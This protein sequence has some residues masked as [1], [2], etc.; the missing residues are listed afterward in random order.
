MYDNNRTI[1]KIAV[2][3]RYLLHAYLVKK[4]LSTTDTNPCDCLLS[5]LEILVKKSDYDA[6]LLR[7]K[8]M[9]EAAYAKL[10]AS[11]STICKAG[12]KE[13][14]VHNFPAVAKSLGTSIHLPFSVF[15]AMQDDAGMPEPCVDVR[16][17]FSTSRSEEVTAVGTSV[18][19]MEDAIYAEG[20]GASY[21]IA[22]HIFETDCKKGLQGRGTAWLASICQ[23]ISIPVYA[24]GGIT[25]DNEDSV[26]ASGAA[27]YC[28]MSRILDYAEES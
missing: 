18:H 12:G 14:I 5:L 4:R 10:A 2:T 8:D 26:L 15:S 13:L 27:G 9:T 16:S 19:S 20:H 21:V 28:M 11:A 17:P 24:I 22:G 3:N 1:K 23:T 6:V 25:E 7:E